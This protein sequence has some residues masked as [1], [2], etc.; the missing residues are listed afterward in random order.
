MTEAEAKELKA[1]LKGELP[2][3]ESVG[4]VKTARG[5]VAVRI[6]SRGASIEDREILCEPGSRNAAAQKAQID[7]FTRVVLGTKARS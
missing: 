3:V 5:W 2:A 1:R 6:T 4:I 7:F